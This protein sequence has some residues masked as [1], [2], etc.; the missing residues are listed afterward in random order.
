MFHCP[1]NPNNLK[2]SIELDV[3]SAHSFE[4]YAVTNANA[5]CQKQS[6]IVRLPIKI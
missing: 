1:T 6:N 2:N 5:A 4:L 3:V